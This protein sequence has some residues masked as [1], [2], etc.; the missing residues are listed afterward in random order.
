VCSSDLRGLHSIGLAACI[1]ISIS[2]LIALTL[3]PSILE[4]YFKKPLLAPIPDIEIL[5]EPPVS[6]NLPQPQ[7]TIESRFVEEFLEFQEANSLD[8][9]ILE[10][11]KVTKKK[12]QAS[13]SKKT[14]GK[15]KKN[16]K[17]N[18]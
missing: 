15:K 4:R 12:S 14:I 8:S 3:L 5:P 11:Q 13:T 2:L 1:G 18:S 16:V 9:L 10:K 17:K 6:Q 7:E